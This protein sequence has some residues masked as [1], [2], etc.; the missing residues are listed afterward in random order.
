MEIDRV[1]HLIT[2][3]LVHIYVKIYVNSVYWKFPKWRHR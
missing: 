2:R 3:N 1:L